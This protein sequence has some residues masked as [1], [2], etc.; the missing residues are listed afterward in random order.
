[1]QIPIAQVLELATGA[2]GFLQKVFAKGSSGENFES[3]L[4]TALDGSGESGKS[5]LEG[6]FAKLNLDEDSLEGLF[7]SG[8]G[9]FLFQFMAELKEMGL[10]VKDLKAL[11][12]GDL[13]AVSNDGLKQLFAALGFDETAIAKIMESDAACQDVLA[14]LSEKL[15]GFL[16]VHAEETGQS[17]DDIITKIFS[18]DGSVEEILAEYN[19]AR[20]ATPAAADK[21]GKVTVQAA[22]QSNSTTSA[23]HQQLQQLVDNVLKQADLPV[24]VQSAVLKNRVQPEGV[25]RAA[26]KVE[27]IAAVLEESLG[28]DKDSLKE[29]L[30]S[31]DKL[32]REQQVDNISRKI[33][34]FLNKNEGKPLSSDIKEALAFLKSVLTDSEFAGIENTLKLFQGTSLPQ[35]KMVISTELYQALADKF[36]DQPDTVMDRHMRQVMDQLRRGMAANL[37]NSEGQVSLKLNPPMLGRVEVN[38]SMLDGA[39]NAAFKT[40][41]AMTRDILQQNMY[42]L[43]EALAEQ[44]I[45]VSN[46]QVTTGFDDRAQQQLAYNNFAGQNNRRGSN[47]RWGRSGQGDGTGYE[48]GSEIDAFNHAARIANPLYEGGLDIFA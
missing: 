13:K 34:A 33:S 14:S 28:I 12:A 20:L 18:D 41:Q 9:I 6:L 27:N 36:A 19:S 17:A 42:I 11:L 3:L 25:H 1:M 47:G 45:K 4:K 16:E 30:F 29:L 22:V 48:S 7:G 2:A 15:K 35:E 21:A 39:M 43:K 26:I 31:T 5:F 24:A 10:S 44:G 46:V 32:S 37:K 40:D 8:S 38:I 23:V